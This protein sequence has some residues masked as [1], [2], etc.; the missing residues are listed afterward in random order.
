[1]VGCGEDCVYLT[2]TISFCF[3]VCLKP[4]GLFSFDALYVSESGHLKISTT[5]FYQLS[6]F[7]DATI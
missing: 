7:S 5:E 2:A 3:L 6:Q 4:S 1:M